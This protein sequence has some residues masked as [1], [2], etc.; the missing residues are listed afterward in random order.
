ML[1]RTYLSRTVSDLSTLFLMP[2]S[3]SQTPVSVSSE[4]PLH[5]VSLGDDEERTSLLKLG[6]AILPNNTTVESLR[7]NYPKDSRWSSF[8]SDSHYI[9]VVNWMYQCRGY[10]KLASEH[11][12]VDLFEIELFDLVHPRPVDDMALLVNKVKLGLLSKIHGK[13]LASLGSFESLFRVYFGSETPLGGPKEDDDEGLD[14]SVYPMFDDLYIDEK[15]SILYEMVIEVTQYPDFRD[16]IDKNKIGPDALRPL[17]IMPSH[18]KNQ[19]S[20]EDYL[21]LFDN[22]ALY[23]RVATSPELSVPR[24]RKLAPKFPEEEYGSDA[25]DI[26]TVNFELIFKDIYGLNT[27]INSL[28]PK[29]AKK[30]KTL[31]DVLT[32]PAFVSNIFSYETR[33]RKILSNRRKDFEMTRLLA[34]R[35][36]SSRIEA[37]EK[38]KEHEE[39]ERKI[40]ELEELQYATNRRSQRTRNQIEYKLKM[41]YTDGLSREERLKMRK[42]LQVDENTTSDAPTATSVSIIS[43]AEPIEIN[44]SGSEQPDSEKIS[45]ITDHPMKLESVAQSGASPVAD[46]HRPAQLEQLPAPNESSLENIVE[47][48][49]QVTIPAATKAS[50]LGQISDLSASLTHDEISPIQE[51]T[52]G[53]AGPKVETSSNPSEDILHLTD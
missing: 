44:S 15:I 28:T 53:T 2:S 13:K 24:K 39:Q 9:Y 23:K 11:F 46:Q 29:K 27:F 6:P 48:S 52:N 3:K 51:V 50:S 49:P 14:T 31:L 16:F 43:S 20:S 40:R 19:S 22:T 5:S 45:R 32:K 12:D 42:G 17:S 33:K 47:V 38:Q 10:I 35:K 25:F 26:A 7:E 4:H 18:I 34:T 8:R 21:L 1:A 30:N 41:D 36:R 37:K